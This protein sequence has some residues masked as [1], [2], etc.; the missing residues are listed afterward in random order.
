MVRS[1][2]PLTTAVQARQCVVLTLLLASMLVSIGGARAQDQAPG[3]GAMVAL[4]V[5][6]DQ[7]RLPVHVLPL[8]DGSSRLLV[9]QLEGLVVLVA[10]DG[11]IADV[12]FLDLRHRVTGLQGEQG[13]FSA[14]L[15]AASRAA[16]RN[17][18][19]HVV[20]AFTER[21]SGDLVIAG[22]PVDPA[23]ERADEQSEVLLLRIPMPEPFHHGGQVAF[24]PDDYLY[25]SVGDGLSESRTLPFTLA[26]AASLGHRRGSLLRIDPFPADDAASYRVPPDNPFVGHQPE[27]GDPDAASE[28]WAF[29]FRNPWRFS[30]D[31][32]TGALFLS[33]P[34]T[35]RWEVLHRVVRGGD[36]GW[37]SREGPSCSLVPGTD[38]LYD[39]D[40]GERPHVPPL[41][42]L[43]HASRDPDGAR[44]IVAGVVVTDPDLPSLAG[45]YL[46]GDVVS[47]RLWALDLE[48]G[49]VE[50]VLETGLRLTAI[51]TG[52][53]DEVLMVGLDGVLARL[54]P[55]T[56][57]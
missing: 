41:V 34:G 17:Q 8:G 25:V 21:D 38:V 43:P 39:P 31:A 15:E 10:P 9:V 19:R 1:T 57:P 27:R 52:A 46:F 45:H 33:D 35:D 23:L 28:I 47:G 13:L 18:A 16:A 7:L 29:G 40:C 26:P 48:R 14:T 20:A 12:P 50:L 42:A 51:V 3:S 22:Y 36:H 37:P 55:I 49:G 5:M 24:G 32:S 11:G 2:A 56:P 54:A 6:T 44:A 4:E 53:N 30:F